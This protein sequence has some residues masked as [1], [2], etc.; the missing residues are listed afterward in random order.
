MKK[1]LLVHNLYR[2]FG[3]EDSAVNG[4][5]KLL[6][7]KYYVDKIIF[8]NS[9]KINFFDF[10]NFLFLTNPKSNKLL[11][12]KIK[13]SR[14]DVIYIHNL[15]FKGSLGLL[16][17][18][19][20][21]QI[22]IVLKIHNFRY[23]CSGTFLS[24]N[25]IES[26]EFCPA[27]G[28]SKRLLLNKYF[29]DSYIK[30]F[31]SIR[32]SKKLFKLIKNLKSLNI[33][34]L[35]E[36]HKNILLNEKIESKRI[37]IMP[38]YIENNSETFFNKEDSF[39]YA[40]RISKEKGVNQIIEAFLKIDFQTYK[41]NIIGTGPELQTLKDKYKSQKIIFHGFMDNNDVI[42]EIQNAKVIISATKLY[43]GQPTLLC[44]ATMNSVPVIFP[45]SGG[46]NEF[47][48]KNYKFLYEQFNY[49]EMQEAMV[50]ILTSDPYKI[51]KENK[52]YLL[53]LINEKSLLQTFELA[54]S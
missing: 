2:N 4:D 46:I 13:E 16:K 45:D 34:L 22:P 15:W 41:L 7:K 40:G 52:S 32:F 42:S 39:L 11:E 49:T 9:D 8:D 50:D 26:K 48:P 23:L 47:L 21:Y 37:F 6:K 30:S 36:H 53:E 27:C 33:L 3:G 31:F 24:K 19:K 29:V 44:E 12:K 14:P 43:E 38:N 28:A 18:A 35:T 25:H 17:V 5:E 51:G 10:I 54:I 1:V 20:R